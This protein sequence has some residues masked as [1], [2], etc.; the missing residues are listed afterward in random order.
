MGSQA[1]RALSVS[2][3]SDVLCPLQRMALMLRPYQFPIDPTIPACYNHDVSHSIDLGNK[4]AVQA[5][6]SAG[7]KVKREQKGRNG[8]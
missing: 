6:P 4:T 1:P 8:G 5:R 7:E 2:V 3:A